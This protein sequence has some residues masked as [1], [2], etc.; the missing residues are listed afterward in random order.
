MA[1]Q[2]GNLATQAIWMC[3]GLIGLPAPSFA[4]AVGRHELNIRAVGLLPTSGPTDRISGGGMTLQRQLDDRWFVGVSVDR[5]VHE[6]SNPG[7][8]ITPNT[9]EMPL[10]R[11]SLSSAVVSAHLGQRRSLGNPNWAWLWSMGI[12]AGFPQRDQANGF[13]QS[14]DPYELV[15]DGGTE[16]QLLGTLGAQYV[17]SPNL[18]VE[19][20]GRLEHHFSS[21]R[22]FER[23]SGVSSEWSSNPV[24]GLHF[25]LNYRF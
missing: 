23:I 12:G 14:G 18:S 22:S 20:S 17:I 21:I 1:A 16:V 11:M 4:D 10:S 3:L 13:T 24:V 19:W 8:L 5:Y 2:N 7:A 9:P 6:F 25:G 15:I